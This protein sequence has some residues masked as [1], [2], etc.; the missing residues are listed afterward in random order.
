MRLGLFLFQVIL[1]GD[2]TEIG[3]FRLFRSQ[4][5]GLSFESTQ[6]PFVPLIQLLFNPADCN[7]LVTLSI[8]VSLT[9]RSSLSL[10]E[11]D[12]GPDKSSLFTMVF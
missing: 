6:L 5:F 12:A 8:S 3:D 1:T 9:G 10:L 2:V 7:V 11:T 4:D